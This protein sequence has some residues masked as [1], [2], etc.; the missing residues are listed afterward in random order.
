[1]SIIQIY[2]VYD[3]E[4]D[5]FKLVDKLITVGADIS[6]CDINENKDDFN[7]NNK[8][9]RLVDVYGIDILPIT[10]LDGEVIKVEKFTEPISLIKMTGLSPKK[11]Q[12]AGIDIL[13]CSNCSRHKS[14]S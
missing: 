1:M 4:N 5:L 7:S 6:I 9:R 14:E 8:I 11:L 2:C 12:R 3:K 10:L 13:K